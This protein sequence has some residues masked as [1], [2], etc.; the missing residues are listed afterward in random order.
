M[1][2]RAW[3]PPTV[4]GRRPASTLWTGSERPQNTYSHCQKGASAVGSNIQGVGA[5]E[6]TEQGPLRQG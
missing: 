2:T 4:V 3:E 1:L 5:E 6:V